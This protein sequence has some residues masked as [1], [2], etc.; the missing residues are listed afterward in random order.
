MLV[1]V[2]FVVLPILNYGCKTVERARRLASIT[3]AANKVMI[4][5]YTELP[6]PLSVS[7]SRESLEMMR[8]GTGIEDRSVI[9]AALV[10]R[11]FDEIIILV[12]SACSNLLFSEKSV[13]GC[14][15]TMASHCLKYSTKTLVLRPPMVR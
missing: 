4:S 9:S 13:F 5:A 2:N 12:P 8:M 6:Y 10:T 3:P 11:T 7:L 14:N 1:G 15:A